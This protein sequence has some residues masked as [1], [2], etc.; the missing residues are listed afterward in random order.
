VKVGQDVLVTAAVADV[1]RE[2]NDQ[3]ELVT[4]A[5]LG[6]P[7]QIMAI[8]SG[9]AQVRLSD[10]EGWI[11]RQNL[12]APA[13]WSEWQANTR[14]MVVQ[15]VGRIHAGPSSR[16]G[17]VSLVFLTSRLWVVA[18]QAGWCQV[19]LPGNRYGW[20]PR[21]VVALRPADTPPQA[22]P[23]EL[24][25]TARRLLD[26]PYLWGGVTPLGIDC[27][28]LVQLVYRYYGYIIP[29]DADQQMAAAIGQMVPFTQLR[30][31]DLI[32]FTEE[33]H[34]DHVA[35][36]LGGTEYIHAN[37]LDMRVAINSFDPLSPLYRADLARPERIA[38]VRRILA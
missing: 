3:A 11:R 31:G 30:A 28:G 32:F 20:T 26:A 12:W 10:Y 14:W 7:A 8:V 34:V 21:G 18:E 33:G 4:Q 1:R 27:S 6:A 35:M 5:L 9:W 19:R 23:S 37:G 36:S 16:T 22:S 29:R 24:A 25:A 15:P 2:A 38:G 17:L 13:S